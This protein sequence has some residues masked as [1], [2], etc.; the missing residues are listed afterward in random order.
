MKGFTDISNAELDEL[1]IGYKRSHPHDGERMLIG[2]LRS[3]NIHVPR[4]RVRQCIHRVDPSGVSA[5]SIKLIQRRKYSMK[6]PNYVWHMD[7]NHKL[8]RWK[9]VIHVPSMVIQGY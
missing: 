5:R 9:F 7:G 3:N 8:I 2:F 4:S 6:G 1:V